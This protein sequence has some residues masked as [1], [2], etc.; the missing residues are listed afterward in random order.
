M[1]TLIFTVASQ[2]LGAAGTVRDAATREPLGGVVVQV[3]ESGVS[4]RTGWDGRFAIPLR[5]NAQLRFTREGYDPAVVSATPNDTA[6]VVQLVPRARSLEAVS[7]TALRGE[8]SA[9][10]SRTVIDRA[11]L[12]SGYFGQ[13]VPLL[14]V[15]APGVTAYSDAGGS[16]FGNY[17]YMR[18]RGMDQTRINLTLDGIPLNDPEDQVFYFS[19]LPDFA[20]SMESVQI[21]RGVGTTSNGTASYAGAVSFE[22]IAL[23]AAPR[24]GEVQAS[25]GSF[26]ST[27]ASA[28]Y[29]TGRTGSFAAYARASAQRTDGYRRH[30]GNRSSS[31]FASAGYV[32]AR[33]LLKV[34][35]TAGD[36]RNDLAYLASDEAAIAGDPRHNPLS[37]E[38]RDHFA[39]QLLGLTATRA[40]GA[41]SSVSATGYTVR[42]DGAYDVR[43]GDELWNFGLDAAVIGAFGTWHARRGP[44]SVDIG[45]HANSYRRYHRL[46][47]RPNEETVYRNTGEK[48]EASAFAKARVG[49]GRT[50]LFADVQRRSAE[51]RYVPDRNAGISSQRIRWDFWNPKLGVTHNATPAL[52][53]Y[54]S[55]GRNS[56]EPTRNDMFAGFDNVDT[57]NVAFVGSLDRVR[58][59]RVTDV[60]AGATYATGSFALRGN[61][62]GMYFRDEIAPIGALSYIGLPL[63]KNVARSR[64]V[65]LELDAEYRGVPR[66]L[67]SAN[68]VMSRS[69]IA[70]Y[71]DDATGAR[72]Q[73]VDALLSPRLVINHSAVYQARRSL[74]LSLH[75]RYVGRSFL[76]NTG[77][78]E[79][80]APRSYVLGAGSE[81]G[82]GRHAVSLRIENVTSARA[83]AS[84]YTDG[85]NSYFYV[86]APRS[87][88]LTARIGL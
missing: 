34:T 36:S 11:K 49:R 64:R 18:L 62:F 80:V 27:R 2:W 55:V 85:T 70:E 43:I 51:F 78:A 72:Y 23:G 84:G 48:S 88:F 59:E 14:I 44:V 9:P 15:T 66:T 24:G 60:E 32:G 81:L 38:E 63:R 87:V 6:L 40:L 67:L 56:R 46:G 37:P 21:Q 10:V 22:S 79:F 58:P 76:A 28:E 30:S 50:Q 33:T 17:T 35:A 39:Q 68:A 71:L 29:Q 12:E 74:S 57:S 4:T 75:G 69:H 5:G 77:D 65:G 3:I 83:Y 20:S 42:S 25:V 26:N 16:G 13:D 1:L 86:S 73:D 31:A 53:V 7:V 61:V 19:N 45:A 52:S 8:A 82:V 47:I 41:E 54:A